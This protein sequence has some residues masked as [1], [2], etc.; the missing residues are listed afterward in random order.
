MNLPAIAQ[1][2]GIDEA[3]WNALTNSVFPGAREESI[4]LAVDYCRA[5]KLDVMKKPCHIVPMKVK[6]Q[7]TGETS[8]RD[9]IMPGIYE[10]R[11]TAFKTGQMAGQDEPVFGDLIMHKGIQAPEWCRV[12]VY[13][14]IGGHRCAFTHTEYFAEACATTGSGEINSMWR[15]RPRG[16]L[17]KCAEA[18][19][20]RKAF[21][22]ELGGV[23][24]AE[25]M[26][27]S[28][29]RIEVASSPKTTQAEVLADESKIRT[30]REMLEATGKEE[31]KMLAY[32]GRDSVE[33]LNAQQA[34]KAIAQL[35]K[36]L[37]DK[38]EAQ[39]PQDNDEI[40]V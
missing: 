34:E 17:A 32:F 26:Q 3:T 1:Q 4:V 27:E 30:I 24:T 31:S 18:G 7:Q 5:R 19:A 33:N 22:D 25:E 8:W 20:L 35:K 13:R 12:T 14:L 28:T 6:D 38:L 2:R 15:K 36:V 37:A 10:Q 40:P 11:T 16:Q 29:D 39:M 9:V 23:M 21:P